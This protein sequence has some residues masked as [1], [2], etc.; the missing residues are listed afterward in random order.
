MILILQMERKALHWAAGAGSEQ[1]LR[2]LLDHDMD[3]DDM[4][5]V[6]VKSCILSERCQIVTGLNSV[7]S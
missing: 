6:R 1:A 5:S 2:L 4:D 7:I 3:V